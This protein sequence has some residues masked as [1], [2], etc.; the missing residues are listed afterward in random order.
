[1]LGAARALASQG[2][3]FGR[4]RDKER[5]IMIK[6]R[7]SAERG[8]ANHGWLDSYHTFSFADYYDERH[9][10]FRSLRVINEDLVDADSGFPTHPHRDMEIVTY[11]LEGSLQHRDSMGNGSVIRPGM[12]Q[13]MTAGTGV[14]H[15]EFNP[16]KDESVHLLQ[17]WILPES[18]GLKPG[19]EERDFGTELDG[20]LR[21]VAS[22]DGRE[23]SLTVH[24]DVSLY[25]GRLAANSKHKHAL[26]ADRHAWLQ[27]ARGGL[28]VSA[29][30]QPVSLSQGD[31][32]AIANHST[33]ELSPGPDGSEILLFD[34]A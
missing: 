25:A 6:I 24:Q 28:T 12:L 16:S 19:Y 4:S 20:Q 29:D 30:G 27:V 34:L 10:H 7:P 21:L 23:D 5:S 33:I 1:M 15:S 22:R 31:G 32:L 2:H 3:N 18:R 8:H 13:R 26:G 11:I 17:I 9:M 14:T